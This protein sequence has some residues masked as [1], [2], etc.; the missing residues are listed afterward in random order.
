MENINARNIIRALS[1]ILVCMFFV[2]TFLVSCS[3]QEVTL[4]AGQIMKGIEFQGEKIVQAYP[5][6]IFYLLLPVSLFIIWC[7]RSGIQE[8]VQSIYTILASG[9]DTVI[10]FVLSARVEE[11]AKRNYCTFETTGWFWVNIFLLIA[12]LIFGVCLCSNT[13]KTDTPLFQAHNQ[14]PAVPPAGKTTWICPQC[15]KE[16]MLSEK[17]CISCGARKAEEAQKLSAESEDDGKT[18]AINNGEKNEGAMECSMGTYKGA[19]IPVGTAEV[20]IGREENGVNIVIKNR[21][22]SRRHCGIR[23]NPSERNYIV[24]DYSTNGT[25]YK[26]GQKFKSQVPTS[27][28]PGTI[29]VIAQSGDEFILK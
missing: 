24:T 29:L 14:I 23:Y 16:N 25:F 28:S 12:V 3:D 2:P 15:R 4:S 11:E 19:V 5:V 7:I 1:L 9:I 26:N 13:L 27:C 22:V 17:F 10:W 21:E 6:M 20:I 18:I 8:K